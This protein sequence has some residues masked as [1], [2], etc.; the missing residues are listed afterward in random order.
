MNPITFAAVGI[1]AAGLFAVSK[2]RAS[3]DYGSAL[4]PNIGAFLA[5]IREGESGNDYSAYV[6]FTGKDSFSDKSDHPIATGEK[7]YIIR[8]DNGLRTSA[9]GAYQIVYSTWLDVA[10]SDFSPYSQDSAAILL[11]KR[12]GA[13]DDIVN[14]DIASAVAKLTPEW[15]MFKQPRW[16]VSA[17]SKLF[18]SKG[19]VLS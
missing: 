14:G 8:P 13:Y 16:S 5:V 3:I 19:G 18:V 1:G 11:I 17:V 15:E 2:A 10:Q 4:D 6:S 7:D 12:R 9:A